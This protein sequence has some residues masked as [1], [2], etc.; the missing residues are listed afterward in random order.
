M[1]SFEYS[2]IGDD[3]MGRRLR[4][5][6]VEAGHLIEE[7]LDDI[8][9]AMESEARQEAPF[10]TGNLRRNISRSKAEMTRP[11]H[12]EAKVGVMRTA[13]YAI[14]VH[15]GTGIFGS[16]RRPIRPRMGNIMAFDILGHTVFTRSV[17]GQRAN[18]FF[19]RA[20]NT[21]ANSYAPAR[22]ERLKHELGNL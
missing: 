1:F 19:R 16:H 7:A 12:H 13:P 5:M 22:L 9:L 11:G 17:K 21:V 14:W 8:A 2:I 20:F 4:A 3:D 6:G 15:E 18:P 10:Q